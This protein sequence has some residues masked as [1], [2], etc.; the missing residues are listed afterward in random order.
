MLVRRTILILLVFSCR[1]AAA[2]SVD[3]V[4]QIKPIFSEACSRCHGSSAQ[5]NGLRLD[6]AASALKG[7]DENKVIVPGKSAES[8]LILRLVS[9]DGGMQMPPTGAL[10]T[11]D[12][13]ILRAWIDQGGEYEVDIKEAQPPKPVDPK[14]KAMIT[15]A[16]LLKSCG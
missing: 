6:T 14:L 1:I 16:R 9:G 12:I 11:E 4:K 7:N 2:D 15:A 13:S 10:P 3:Y 5:K 8:K